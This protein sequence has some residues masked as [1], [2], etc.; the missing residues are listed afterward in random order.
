MV[1]TVLVALWSVMDESELLPA[2]IPDAS[3]QMLLLTCLVPAA[4]RHR[5]WRWSGSPRPANTRAG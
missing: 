5:C 3:Q 1:A 2:G 4:L